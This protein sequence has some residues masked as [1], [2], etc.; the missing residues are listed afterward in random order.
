MPF[1]VL[2]TDMIDS[3]L[4]VIYGCRELK[5]Y[6]ELVSKLRRIWGRIHQSFTDCNDLGAFFSSGLKDVPILEFI[7]PIIRQLSQVDE[8]LVFGWVVRRVLRENNSAV[9]KGFKA[10]WTNLN[11]I[12]VLTKISADWRLLQELEI[13]SLESKISAK[14]ALFEAQGLRSLEVEDMGCK[15]VIEIQNE[16]CEG[17]LNRL[18]LGV[19]ESSEAEHEPDEK[20][21]KEASKFF[22]H[23]EAEIKQKFDLFAEMNEEEKLASVCDFLQILKTMVQDEPQVKIYM[24]E[25]ASKTSVFESI[26]AGAAIRKG[27]MSYYYEYLN[28]SEELQCNRKHRLKMNVDFF[29]VIIQYLINCR[30]IVFEFSTQ[31]AAVTCDDAKLAGDT[32]TTVSLGFL[33]ISTINTLK[34]ALATVANL[35]EQKICTQILEV[36]TSKIGQLQ[37]YEYCFDSRMVNLALLSKYEW[38]INEIFAF[39]GRN[40][41]STHY[42]MVN[43]FMEA[44]QFL[45][46]VADLG[47]QALLPKFTRFNFTVL[48]LQNVQPEM[49]HVNFS[50]FMRLMVIIVSKIKERHSGRLFLDIVKELIHNFDKRKTIVPNLSLP[51]AMLELSVPAEDHQ[52]SGRSLP[53]NTILENV[54]APKRTMSISMNKKLM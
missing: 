50:G 32:N 17:D 25:D 4:D 27:I 30:L 34:S 19:A 16:V 33:L 23:Y 28:I 51:K 22:A 21:V 12:E 6:S 54:I 52:R 18:V 35:K 2:N 45:Q 9:F 36:I 15:Y 5:Q 46:L 11:A 41:L 49:N 8:T 48:F 26:S 43:K 37:L 29:K 1:D 10:G 39:F 42:R 14:L 24:R 40:E 13:V 7:Q 3:S 44:K 38:K 20:G 47:I 31:T 53:R